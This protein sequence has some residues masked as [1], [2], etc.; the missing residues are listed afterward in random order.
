MIDY[1][2]V[3]PIIEATIDL[4]RQ[5]PKS[6]GNPMPDDYVAWVICQELRRSGWA[7]VPT[8]QNSN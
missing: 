1:R 6:E 3:M 8:T 5:N 4:A 2:K 7:I